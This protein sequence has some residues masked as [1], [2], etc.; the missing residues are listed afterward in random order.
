[1][2]IPRHADPMM[3]AVSSPTPGEKFAA[4]AKRTGNLAHRLFDF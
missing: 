4:T 3:L 1:M 2:L